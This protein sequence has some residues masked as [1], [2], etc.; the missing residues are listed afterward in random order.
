MPSFSG[1]TC[2]CNLNDVITVL[3]RGDVL[4]VTTSN[5]MDVLLP[6]LPLKSVGISS[7]ILTG[8]GTCV[9]RC[10]SDK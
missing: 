8:Q 3:S 4:T 1:G 6:D 9:L 10:T 7:L 2:Y 5:K